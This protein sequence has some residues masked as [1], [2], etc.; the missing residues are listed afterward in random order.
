MIDL[1]IKEDSQKYLE[2]IHDIPLG[3]K[4]NKKMKH[5]LCRNFGISWTKNGSRGEKILYTLVTD[6]LFERND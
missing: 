3:C 5:A 1:T 2:N 6:T 4:F